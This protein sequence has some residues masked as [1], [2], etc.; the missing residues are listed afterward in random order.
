[1]LT[2]AFARADFE[3]VDPEVQIIDRLVD[4]LAPVRPAADDPASHAENNRL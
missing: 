2:P 3:A 1:L 4:V